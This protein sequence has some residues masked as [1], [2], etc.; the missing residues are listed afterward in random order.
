MIYMMLCCGLDALLVAGNILCNHINYKA[1]VLTVH[2]C[3]WMT[4]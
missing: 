2:G 1:T 4:A 3:V